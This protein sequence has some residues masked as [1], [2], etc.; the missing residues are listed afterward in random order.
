MRKK[1]SWLLFVLAMLL[2]TAGI[3]HADTV[4]KPVITGVYNTAKGGEVR[5]ESQTKA[6]KYIV[7]RKNNGKRI[8]AATVSGNKTAFIDKSIKSN[9]W[10]KTYFYSVA[11]VVD[12][13]EYSRS[14]E[15]VL[16]RLAPMK[17]TALKSS[18]PNTVSIQYTVSTGSN[19]A[20]GY[21]IQYAGSKA[22]LKNQTASFHSV[23]VKGRKKLQAAVKGLQAGKVYYFRVR[24]FSDYKKGGKTARS[25]SQFSSI[26]TVKVKGAAAEVPVND[27]EE[28]LSDDEVPVPSTPAVTP[29]TTPAPAPVIA[30]TPTVSAMCWIP[31]SGNCYHSISNCGRM[32]PDKA[33]YISISDALSR[34]YTKCT[35]C[36]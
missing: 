4:G 25:W 27:T 30:D 12:G 36:R 21:E 15:K 7:Y 3:V 5:W 18:K 8:K 34:G 9:C 23:T 11:P 14:A 31:A 16:Q 6:D 26:R 32:N 24:A 19:K 2:C 22:D 13:K 1:L 10:G 28:L 17:I 33:S 29:I 35:K 20:G